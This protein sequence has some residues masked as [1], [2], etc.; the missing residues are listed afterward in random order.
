M[1][2]E[3]PMDVDVA[4]GDSTGARHVFW[5]K[6]MLGLISGQVVGG[7]LMTLWLGGQTLVGTLLVGTVCSI[8]IGFLIWITAVKQTVTL[9]AADDRFSVESRGLLGRLMNEWGGKISE[10]EALT[11]ESS[12]CSDGE[13]WWRW[14]AKLKNGSKRKLPNVFSKATASRISSAITTSRGDEDPRGGLAI[15]NQEPGKAGA[16]TLGDD[17]EGSVTVVNSERRPPREGG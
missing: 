2:N 12:P 17:Q 15:V 8:W 7:T 9:F 16:L 13:H 1:T 10:L 5:E 3:D 14:Y 11:G 4:S 6:D